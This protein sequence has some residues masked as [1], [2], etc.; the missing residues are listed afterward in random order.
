MTIS[1]IAVVFGIISAIGFIII[2]VYIGY[3][4]GTYKNT[5]TVLK[6]TIDDIQKVSA[7]FNKYFNS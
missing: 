2:S 4:Y 3:K 7:M 1:V 6:G 5:T